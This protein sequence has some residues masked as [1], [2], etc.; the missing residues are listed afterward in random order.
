[1]KPQEDP[2]LVTFNLRGKDRDA[3]TAIPSILDQLLVF[4]EMYHIAE[5][6]GQESYLKAG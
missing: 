5:R 2:Q 4:P 3:F 6:D 1:M